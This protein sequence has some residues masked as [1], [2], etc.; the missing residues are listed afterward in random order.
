MIRRIFPTACAARRHAPRWVGALLLAVSGGC[1]TL[2]PIRDHADSADA[3]VRECAGWYAALDAAV[4]AAGVRDAQASR[5]AGFPYLRVDRHL[6]SM[7]HAARADERAFDALVDRLAALDSTARAHE[8]ANLPAERRA[9]LWGESEEP[10]I[11]AA[12][13]RTRECARLLRATDMT[14]PGLRMRLGARLTV[15]DDYVDLYRAIGLYPLTRIP[16]TA[17][18]RRQIDRMSAAF[19]RDLEAAVQGTVVRY[20]PPS[21]PRLAREQIRQ[22][23]ARSGYNA[24]RLPEPGDADLDTLFAHFAPSFEID[25]VADYDRPGALR[26]RWGERPEVDAAEPTVYRQAAYTRYHGVS[27]LQLVYTVWFAERPSRG[28]LDLLAGKLDA[29]VLRVTLAPDGGALLYDSMHACG[30]YHLFITTPRAVALAAPQ[31]EPEWA[32]VAQ[33]LPAGQIDLPP[34]VRIATGTHYVERIYGD[35]TDSLA[36]YEFKPYEELRS[37]PRMNGDTRSVFGPEGFIAGT[38]RAER[39][40]FWP[41]GIANAGAMRQWGRHATAFVGRRHFDDADLIERRFLLDLR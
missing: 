2:E 38:E 20:S 11:A 40:V 41:M 35:A 36:R 6:A 28:S 5:V 24:L 23:L 16:F 4:E 30:C 3:R 27:L 8:I 12:R 1:A 9:R 7:R 33:T 39:L 18:V 15:P 31:D 21:R 22:I 10:S 13:T 25:T 37:L 32:F 26:W 19:G 17:G 14:D 29:V 34:V